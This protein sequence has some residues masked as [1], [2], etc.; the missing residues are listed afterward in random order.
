VAIENQDTQ[1]NQNEKLIRQAEWIKSGHQ[2]G[3]FKFE[4]ADA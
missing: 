1:M 3:R 4:Q 2:A